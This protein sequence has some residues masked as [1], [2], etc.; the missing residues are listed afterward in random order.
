MTIRE[1]EHPIGTLTGD[2]VPGAPELA[3]RGSCV[4]G[5]RTLPLTE[6]D[7]PNVPAGLK[8]GAYPRYDRV[9]K[10]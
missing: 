5:V 10:G 8:D 3:A 1:S 2:P 7:Q 9:L 4:T 6:P